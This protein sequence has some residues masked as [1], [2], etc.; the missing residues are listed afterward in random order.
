M[1]A[2][3]VWQDSRGY[4]YIGTLSGFVRYDGRQLTS[5]LK[6]RRI[7]IVDFQEVDGTVCAFRFKRYWKVD[8][9]RPEI[10][11]QHPTDPHGQRLLNNFNAV[12]LPPGYM[13]TEDVEE[14]HRYLC[15]ITTNGILPLT[16]SP[17]LDEMTPDRKLFL[18]SNYVYVPTPNGL[19]RLDQQGQA[20]QLTHQPDIYSLCRY[21]GRLL[22]F[23]QTGAFDVDS[24]VSQSPPHPQLSLSLSLPFSFRYQ[25]M[26]TDYG[27]I[28]RTTH[29]GEL[30]IADAHSLYRLEDGKM[31]QL[32]TGFNLIKY[33]FVDRWDRLWMAT[34]QGVYCFF[35]RRFINHYLS[36]DND[37]VRCVAHLPGDRLVMGTLNGKLLVDGNMVSDQ[38]DD[39]FVPSSATVG[40]KVY[41]ACR[42]DVVC[43]EHEEARWLRLP[44]NR[45]QFV[46]EA[47][48]KVILGTRQMILAYDPTTEATDTLTTG[49]AHPWCAATDGE[50]RLWVG[51]TFGLYCLNPGQNDARQVGYQNQ[52]LIVATMASNH[53][54]TVFFASADSL[55]TISN[56]QVAA[57]PDSLNRLLSGH[58]VR[59][60][61]FSPRGFLVAAVID[62]FFVIRLQNG[63]LPLLSDGNIFFFNHRNGFTLIEPQQAQMAEA[64]DG[65]VFMAC[66]EGVTSF[67]PEDLVADSQTDTYIAP[68]TPWWQRWW[69][70]AISA[71]IVI[72]IVVALV[73]LIERQRHRRRLRHLQREKKQKELQISAIRLKAIPH[74]HA[75]VLAGI[76]YF[77][78][79]NST[80]EATRYLKLYSDF[81]NQTLT[82][83]DRPA[84]SVAEEVDYTRIYLQLEQLRYG[85]RLS[86]DITVDN[87]VNQQQLLPTMLLH[88][89][90]QNALK[91]GIGNKPHGGHISIR[92]RRHATDHDTSDIVVSVTDNGVGRA[93]AAH[94]NKN[95]TQQGLRIL[96]EQIALY[97]QTNRRPICQTVTDLHDEEGHPAG[98]CFEL[99]VPTDYHFD[100]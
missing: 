90:C 9:H 46:T 100:T 14:R 63:Q 53:Q 96:M 99:S 40:G 94:L 35:N 78:M 38:P 66:L 8:P 79:N 5:F 17:L 32:A 24:L 74:F 83:I 95:S 75:N 27:L 54:G 55:F 56:G 2:E 50:G 48:G 30:L 81:T 98:T 86:Y 62:G 13:L 33:L 80:A 41:M 11:S 93:A 36:D 34:Y 61:H 84:R 85:E 22:A 67:K 44:Y 31:Q 71:V 77:L 1:Q 76:E 18:D 28:V 6:G 7:N 43:V 4:I 60:L 49:I 47:N 51:S 57:A 92:I 45:Y 88:T 73:T 16:A 91:H 3:T 19:Y 10:I 15:R 21:N 58:E 82:D 87:D 23:A 65:T 59:S 26:A 70:L 69:L 89:Y 52:T 12:D 39:F 37:I 68:P 97:N 20:T 25:D 64:D 42:G 29:S 72:V